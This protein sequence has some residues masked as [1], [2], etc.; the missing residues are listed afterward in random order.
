M[1]TISHFPYFVIPSDNILP[2]LGNSY[3]K[4]VDQEIDVKTRCEKC[5]IA[6]ADWVHNIRSGICQIYQQT[7]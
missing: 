7:N 3:L 2:Y 5:G 4:L 1:A 6:A